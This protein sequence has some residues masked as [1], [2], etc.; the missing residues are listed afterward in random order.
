MV[1]V[2]KI[3]YYQYDTSVKKSTTLK[4]LSS[5]SNPSTSKFKDTH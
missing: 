4:G 2:Y 5:K 3:Q 1:S